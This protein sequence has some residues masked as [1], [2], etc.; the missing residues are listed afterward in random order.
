M[1]LKPESATILYENPGRYK[2]ECKRFRSMMDPSFDHRLDSSA[3]ACSLTFNALRYSSDTMLIHI[4]HVRHVY[5]R[6]HARARAS[7]CN[8]AA[9]GSAS[10]RYRACLI[11]LA[12]RHLSTF[13]AMQRT[14][15]LSV[16]SARNPK[17]EGNSTKH[18]CYSPETVRWFTITTIFKKDD[19]CAIWSRRL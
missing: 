13:A 10:S 2:S 6:T 5:V 9:R 7:V 3:D 19:E 8:A 12:S 4:W 16:Q 1:E 11:G 14:R 17:K 18:R 15:R